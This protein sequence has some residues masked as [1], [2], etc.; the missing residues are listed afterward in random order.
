MEKTIV[1]TDQAPAPVG[2]YSQAVKANG[3]VFIS[4][5]IAIDPQT[6]TLKLG[7]FEEQSR[8]VLDN[9]KA[10]VE[11]SGSSLDQ[12]VKVNIFLKDLARFGEFNEIYSDYFGESKPA[13]ACVE[14]SRLPKE[15]EVEVEA[16]AL[17]P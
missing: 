11:A 3:F 14:V 12:V 5:Q 10:I 1:H 6:N 16:V 9:L 8:L 7:S 2:P 13:R 17:C 15:V 4:G